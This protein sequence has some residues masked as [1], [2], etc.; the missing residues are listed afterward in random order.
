MVVAVLIMASLDLKVH[1]RGW[2]LRMHLSVCLSAMTAAHPCRALRVPLG[3]RHHPAK[4]C[5]DAARHGRQHCWHLGGARRG[6]LP[7]P[8]LR[9]RERRACKRLGASALRFCR[10]RHLRCVP[11][12]SE[13]LAA[14]HCGAMLTRWPAPCHDATPREVRS[15]VRFRTAQA[16]CGILR[17]A[18]RLF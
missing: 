6:P 8:R 7:V 1:M 10:W 12:K 15:C 11:R 5:S 4:P 18:R 17:L 16:T 13:W 9:R 3:A 14:W 2:A